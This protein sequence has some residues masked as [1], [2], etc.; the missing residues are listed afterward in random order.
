MGLREKKAEQ[1]RTRII[2]DAMALFS[3]KGYE[4]TTMEA[5]AEA[6]FLSPSTLYRY[7]PTKD[8]IVFASFTSNTAKF[9]LVFQE[10]LK[11]MTVE[12]ALAEAIFA[13]L[14]VEDAHPKHAAMVRSILGQSL[15]ARAR[16]WDY[17]GEQRQQ[18]THD[19]ATSLGRSVDDPA[20]MLTA[21]IA[22]EVLM[23]TADTWRDSKGR[24]SSHDTAVNLMQIL[25]A[26]GVLY[27]DPGE[28]EKPKSV[29]KAPV[30]RAP[31][32]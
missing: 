31:R 9:S 26:G 14:A 1:S 22:L 12:R 19:L 18:L 32:A 6:A 16:L 7:F 11:E 3:R 15:A 17:L 30:K 28:A 20:L 23:M 10:R 29:P 27:P 13:V 25:R 4:E 24:V 8:S 5:I 2:D 21:R